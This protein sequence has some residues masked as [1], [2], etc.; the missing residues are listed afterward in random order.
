[1]KFMEKNRKVIKL[2]VV[3]YDVYNQR[4][5]PLNEKPYKRHDFLV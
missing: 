3:E 2:M 4:M 1:M 5:I